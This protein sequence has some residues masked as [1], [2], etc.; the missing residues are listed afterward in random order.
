MT[1]WDWLRGIEKEFLFHKDLEIELIP[2][3][4][5]DIRRLIHAVKVMRDALQLTLDKHKHWNHQMKNHNWVIHLKNAHEKALEQAGR[6][7]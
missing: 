7:E 3:K 5:E 2:T 6:M 1:D 4:K